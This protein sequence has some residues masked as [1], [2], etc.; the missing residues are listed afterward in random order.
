MH[1]GKGNLSFLVICHM[2]IYHFMISTGFLERE[3][4]LNTNHFPHLYFEKELVKI[5]ALQKE[6]KVLQFDLY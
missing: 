3:L 1:I 5:K 2:K 6:F 4:G